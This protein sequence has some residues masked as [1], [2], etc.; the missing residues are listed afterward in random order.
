M[1]TGPSAGGMSFP[2]S[3]TQ[4][5]GKGGARPVARQEKEN[6]PA[7]A[8]NAFHKM[9]AQ[10]RGGAERSE[11]QKLHA[12]GARAGPAG[13]KGVGGGGGPGA[14]YGSNSLK[15][16]GSGGG[17]AP[18]SFYGSSSQKS[19]GAFGYKPPAKNVAKRCGVP[20]V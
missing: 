11:L 17:I 12:G 20:R 2:S 1:W 3:T 15:G 19:G 14:L 10:A 9:D 5:A 13:G 16:R 6:R 4:F 8:R 7:P 18:L